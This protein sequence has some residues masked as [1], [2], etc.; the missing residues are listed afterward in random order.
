M[1]KAKR[2]IIAGAGDVGQYLAKMLSKEKHEITVIDTDAERL[3]TIGNQYDL[4]TIEGSGTSFKT[5]EDAKIQ[6]MDLFIAVTHSEETNLLSAMLAK[7]LG[8]KKTIA[9][10][11]NTEYINPLRKLNFINMGVDRMIY[12]EKIAAKE[13]TSLIR[14][15]GTNEVFEFSGG[16]LKLFVLT[17]D[18]NA[19]IVGKTLKEAT[20]M[21]NSIDYRAVAIS[22][23][24]QTIIPSGE[25]V[26]KIGDIVYVIT[27]PEG[28]DS[29]MK[30]SGKDKHDIENIMILGG[31]RIGQRVAMDLGSSCR[32]KLIEFNEKKAQTIAERLEKCLVIHGDGRNLELLVEEDIQDMDAF[33]AV[34]GD[35]ETNV[36]ACALAKKFGVPKAIA[37]IE[38]FDYFDIASKMG[39]ESIINKKLSAASHIYTF[40]MN[41]EVSSIKCLTGTNAELL[42]FV[43]GENAKITKD[44]LRNINF[45]KE[46]IVGGYIRGK[47]SFI[48]KGDTEIKPG[49]K[50]VVFSLPEALSKVET[51]FR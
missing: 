37:E 29:L 45:P 8:A 24:G 46:S 5:L 43:V 17:L 14:Q 9:R 11:D 35:S 21:V 28:V 16:K 47:R 49:D 22:R 7:R 39:I 25:D 41:A 38:N 27:S 15:T 2:I 34:T 36:L 18:E 50:V 42:E 6:S 32:I 20:K 13:I 1:P 3:A 51:F 26:M 4:M 30:N 23:E 48:A 44:V 40:T 12:P 19:A 10:I 31:S 33:I